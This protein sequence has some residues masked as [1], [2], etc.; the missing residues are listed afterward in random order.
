MSYHRRLVADASYMHPCAE[1]S[2]S[3]HVQHPC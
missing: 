1:K 2:E 3:L